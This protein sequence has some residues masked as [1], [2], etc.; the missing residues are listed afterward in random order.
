ME[1]N[2]RSENLDINESIEIEKFFTLFSFAN[3][4]I[5]LL[6]GRRE[7][8]LKIWTKS[9]TEV[10]SHELKSLVKYFCNGISKINIKLFANAKHESIS[11]KHVEC[12]GFDS[13]PE[14]SS[15]V[16]KD[17]WKWIQRKRKCVFRHWTRFAVCCERT[18]QKRWTFYV[19]WSNRIKKNLAASR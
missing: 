18:F 1:W 15:S 14:K 5:C 13:M 8:K 6:K 7:K 12:H 19:L 16:I 2:F 9:Q 11:R 10:R 3:R 17:T 4:S